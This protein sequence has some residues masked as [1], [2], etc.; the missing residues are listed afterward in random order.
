M[1]GTSNLND[2][3][4]NILQHACCKLF[5]FSKSVI[6]RLVQV[7]RALGCEFPSAR[8]VGLNPMVTILPLDRCARACYNRLSNLHVALYHHQPRSSVG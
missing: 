5:W 1:L 4:G 3:K 8:E 6:C 7:V 2:E